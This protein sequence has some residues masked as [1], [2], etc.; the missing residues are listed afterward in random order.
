MGQ[1]E[2]MVDNR[3][4][5]WCPVRSS[6]SFAGASVV[7]AVGVGG[8]P[9]DEEETAVVAV[10]A[11]GDHGKGSLDSEAMVPSDRAMEAVG[12]TAAAVAAC[13]KYCKG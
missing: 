13:C 1:V 12:E 9:A 7:A 6:P 2:V 10:G 3:S 5:L 4:H 8:R 11:G